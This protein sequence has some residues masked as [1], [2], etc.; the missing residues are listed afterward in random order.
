MWALQRV[1]TSIVIKN[2]K[3]QSNTRNNTRPGE[4]LELQNFYVKFHVNATQTQLC[5]EDVLSIS[6]HIC[7]NQALS[8][9]CGG[10]VIH[11]KD[12][13]KIFRSFKNNSSL[14][15]TLHL[16]HLLLV[17]QHQRWRRVQHFPPGWSSA[18]DEP[19]VFIIQNGQISNNSN[20][21]LPQCWRGSSTLPPSGRRQ[22]GTRWW[23]S[24][25]CG[26]SPG[27]LSPLALLCPGI[28]PG[29]CDEPESGLLKERMIKG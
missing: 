2:S 14:P 18:K 4:S 25:G 22:I 13:C 21:Y 17:S 15:Y 1:F 16:S 6:I 29:K 5:F 27:T 19:C 7:D 10:Q 23:R 3:Q 24:P 26:Q 8:T 9:F 11:L 28:P 12:P 20:E